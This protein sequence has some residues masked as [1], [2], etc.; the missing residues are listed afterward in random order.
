MKLRCESAKKP[1]SLISSFSSRTLT[2]HNKDDT[3]HSELGHLKLF[4]VPKTQCSLKD[5]MVSAQEASWYH[6]ALSHL[7]GNVYQTSRL[8]S[9][10]GTAAEEQK[11][12]LASVWLGT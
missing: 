1:P 10:E 11:E 4:P 2:C 5:C 9:S 3:N 7:W 12:T 8:G 6:S